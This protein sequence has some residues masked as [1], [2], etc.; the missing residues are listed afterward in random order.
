MGFITRPLCDKCKNYSE[1]S[2]ICLQG[3][4]LKAGT[5]C[6]SFSEK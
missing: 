1:Q 2:D 4:K 5:Y 6:C 3:L